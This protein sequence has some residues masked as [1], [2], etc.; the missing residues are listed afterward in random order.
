MLLTISTTHKPATD[1]GFLLH[2]HPEGVHEVDVS[3]G[4]VI[5]FYPEASEARCTFAMTVEIDPIALVR[6]KGKQATGVMDQYV[7]DRPYAASSFLSVALGRAV[8]TAFAGRSKERQELADTAIPLEATV[9]PLP[10]RGEDDVIHRL[11][12]PLGYRVEVEEH[13]LDPERPDWGVSPYVSLKLEAATRLKSL[14]E[15][16]FVLIPVLDNRKHYYVSKDELEKLLRKGEDWLRDHPEK[17]FIARRYLGH[18]RSLAEQA[19]ERLAD[20]DLPEEALDKPAQDDAEEELEKPIRLH[21]QRLDTVTETLK[22][23]GARRVLDL[24]CGE[25]KLIARLLK[26]KQFTEVVGADVSIR[27]LEIAHRRLKLDRLSERQRKRVHLMQGAL[28]YRDQRFSGF[29]A[30][31]L[32]EVIEHLDADRLPALERTVFEFAAPDAVVVTTPNRDYNAKFEGL[33]SGAFRHADHR[34]EWTRGEFEA[35]ARSAAATHGYEVRFAPIGELDPE[36]GAA[37]QMGI[38]E[39]SR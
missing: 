31:A 18:L 29:D 37:S 19:L 21:D 1:L 8:N 7:N 39:R 30:I 38:F 33:T 22:E 26:D 27:P 3:F 9:Q 17:E 5:M 35:W 15:H 6:G 11:F 10:R 25:G 23:F 28:T 4:K 32:V 20:D 14:L 2:K 36:L 13:P 16:L 12:E 34:F 24:G